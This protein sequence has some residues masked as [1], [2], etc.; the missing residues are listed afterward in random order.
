MIYHASCCIQHYLS[1]LN[2]V[3]YITFRTIAALV[4]ALTLTLVGTE[5]FIRKYKGLF[6]SQARE[7]TPE[8]HK[9]KK[10]TP[11]MG[12]LIIVGATLVTCLCWCN[13]ARIHTWLLLLGF[14]AF[15]AIGFWDDWEK[16]TKKR[17]ILARQKWVLQ[18]VCALVLAV[19]L[20]A[21]HTTTSTISLPFLKNACP[22]LGWL[23]IA[24]AIFVIVGTSNAV[25]LTDG[26]DGLA[27]GVLLPNLATFTLLN[28][29][30]GHCIIA[31]YLLVPF[32]GNSEATVVGGA[33]VGAVLGFLWYNAFPAQIIMGDVGSLPL[34]AALALMALMAKQELL[35]AL[36]GGV[37]V[38]ETLSVVAQV[39]SF[40]LRGKRIFKMAPLHHHFELRGLH[41]TKITTR[42]VIVSI[43]LC[44]L[45]LITLKVR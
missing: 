25:N 26:L 21:T 4:Q 13:L 29:L 6:L 11:T 17:G 8:T 36:S 9:Q 37:F 3:H 42:F 5:I 39:G 7:C 27:C 1:A 20:L 34:G 12:G 33:L 28:Y 16:I 24:W 22:D 40:K 30:A 10:D 45:A 15:G 41:E 18:I 14:I 32:T 35:L 2:V 19:L 43:V 23:F 44:M 38:V 31:L